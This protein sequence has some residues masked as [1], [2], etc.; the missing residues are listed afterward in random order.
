MPL[1]S[2]NPDDLLEQLKAVIQALMPDNAG[3]NNTQVDDNTMQTL[4]SLDQLG[5]II[6]GAGANAN[7][8]N[9]KPREVTEIGEYGMQALSNCSQLAGQQNDTELQQQ[10]GLLAVG[11]VLWVA[12]QGGEITALEPVVDTL[13]WLA[14]NTKEHK[15]LSQLSDMVGRIMAACNLDIRSD[16]ENMNPGRPWR[17]ININRGII[18][19]RSQDPEIMDAAFQT[20]IKNLPQDAPGFFAE[21]MSEMERVGYPEHVREVMTRYYEQWNEPHVIH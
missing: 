15:A 9:L 1:P 21:G 13:A 10:I 11:I 5:E 17:V 6:T 4:A 7:G 8:G 12:S 16:L 18:A 20:L 14:N 2:D 3:A 19:T